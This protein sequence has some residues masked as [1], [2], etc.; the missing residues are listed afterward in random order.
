MSLPVSAA[1]VEVQDA[2]TWNHLCEPGVLVQS[3]LQ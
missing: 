3:R 1:H 2:Q